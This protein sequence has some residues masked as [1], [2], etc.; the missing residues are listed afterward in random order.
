MIR[1]EK[2]CF[3]NSKATV[4]KRSPQEFYERFIA[5]TWQDKPSDALLL[6]SL[7]HCMAM[8]PWMFAERFAV[9]PKADKRTK[10]G[11]A[12]KAAFDESIKGKDVEVVTDDL[13]QKAKCCAAALP[14]HSWFGPIINNI[15]AWAII[16]KPVYWNW[17][18]VDCAGTPDM[19]LLDSELIIDIKTTKDARPGMFAR[20]IGDF[21]YAR[22]AAFYRLGV[23]E[24]FGIDCR[25]IFAVVKSSPPY[26]VACYEIGDRSIETAIDE[27]E[28]LCREYKDRME[29]GVWT[30]EWSDGINQ[31]ELNRWYEKHSFEEMIEDE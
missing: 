22:Q 2:D 28:A 1:Y 24:A 31:I 21:G 25:F 19:L 27:M 12:I 4:L 30:P 8:E 11:K 10:E 5:K 20:S 13:L 14:S 17:L 23:R 16:E 26:E 15:P 7:V 3:T 6:G 9:E 18:G 29:R